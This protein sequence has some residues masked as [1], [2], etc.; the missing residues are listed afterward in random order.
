MK[1]LFVFLF[2]C[3]LALGVTSVFADQT[4]TIKTSYG[5]QQLV[6][7]S[8]PIQLKAAYEDMARLY[9]EERHA[10][11]GSLAQVDSLLKNITTLK[12]DIAK[13]TGQNT[14]L[15]NEILVLNKQ[16]NHVDFARFFVEGEYIQGLAGQTSTVGVGARVEILEQASIGLDYQLPS[17]IGISFDWRIK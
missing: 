6:V 2:F 8:D 10:H 15:S 17:G 9:L 16:V 7:P 4:V 11:Q 12:T 1:K 3:F 5:S 14:I 13:L